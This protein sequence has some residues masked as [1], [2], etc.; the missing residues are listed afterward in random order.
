M[1]NA[2]NTFDT[3]VTMVRLQNDNLHEDVNKLLA[4]AEEASAAVAELIRI[5]ESMLLRIE[6]EPRE[7]VFPNSAA[8]D[9]LRAALARCNGGAA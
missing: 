1:S 3:L 4:M 6:L 9:E 2:I 7:A 8:R 5:A